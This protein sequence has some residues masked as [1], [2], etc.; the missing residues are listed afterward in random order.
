MRSVRSSYDGGAGGERAV[1]GP[2][3]SP[4]NKTLGAGQRQQHEQMIHELHQRHQQQQQQQQQQLYSQSSSI[5]PALLQQLLLKMQEMEQGLYADAAAIDSFPI[6][7]DIVQ[8]ISAP[9]AGRYGRGARCSL[10]WAV[11]AAV[12][13]GC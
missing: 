12:Y 13:C 7:N 5:D 4:K 10:P 9:Q 1:V 11:A 8:P 6:F 2:A 3:A